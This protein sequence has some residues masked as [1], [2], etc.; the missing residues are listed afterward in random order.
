MPQLIP[1]L[2]NWLLK[3]S[4]ETCIVR[5]SNNLNPSLALER[6]LGEQL[7]NALQGAVVEE[8][9]RK[10]RIHNNDIYIKSMMEGHSIKVQKELLPD[11]YALCYDVK[12]K[13]NFEDNV[14]FYITGSSEVNAFSIA[15]EEEGGAHIVN[16][17]SGLVELM[18][19]DELR[20]V[21][22]HE[23]GH[24]IN[25]DTALSRLISFV[26]PEGTAAPISLQ[27]KIRL[28]S[29]LAELVAD[30]YGYIATEN[31]ATCVTALFK[32]ASGLDLAKMNVSID[33][34]I[35]DN[36]KRLD[37]FLSD[38]GLSFAT[39]PVNPIRVQALNLFAT[40]KS[41]EELEE[42]IGDLLAIL[43]KI[44]DSEL[45]EHVARFVAA[46]GLIVANVDGNVTK[47]EVDS[48]INSLSGYKIFPKKFLDEIAG[49]NVSEI[50]Q[51]A[52]SKVLEINP[53]MRTE[54]LRYIIQMVLADKEI[55]K[56]ELD[57][58]YAVGE[59]F[60]LSEIEIAGE[61]A[62]AIQRGYIPSMDSIC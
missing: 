39:H 18:T 12:R 17:N 14:D 50:F 19:H 32:M 5:S 47:D 8:V 45:D 23:L 16:L 4:S 35:A 33:A 21:V 57:L 54:L 44:G 29:Q 1:T 53:G 31:L 55:S 15:A 56:E 3:P 13:L 25:K 58:V 7:Y 43:L 34:L 46:A 49:G 61:I 22:G 42:K 41:D 6:Q 27:Y 59:S 9:L 38:K 30:R 37:F 36:N 11:L 40:C 60:D 10:T 48:I 26:F 28:H 2:L 51:D 24:L 62:L 20:F 52:A